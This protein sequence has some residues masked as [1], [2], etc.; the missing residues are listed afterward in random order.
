MHEPKTRLFDGDVRIETIH[1]LGMYRDNEKYLE[2][3]F[4]MLETF[5]LKYDV[6]FKY[7][8]FENNSKDDTREK[9]QQF[10]KTR[11]NSRLILCNVKKDYENIG[12]G[13]NLNRIA[14]LAKLRNKF[15][16]NCLPFP[17]NEWCLIVDSN[18][19]FKQ[20]ILEQVFNT[21]S[22][23][24]DNIAMMCMYTQQLMIPAIHK[25]NT[26]KPILIKHF[27]DTY[28]FYDVNKR[29]FYPKCAFQKCEACSIN[30]A[31]NKNIR[32]PSDQPVVD[33][34]S[35]F[36]GFVF[37]KSDIMNNTKIRW[38][39]VCYDMKT[40][41]SLCEHVIFCDR[42]KTLTDQ[43]IVVLQHIDTL[44]RTI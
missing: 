5:E 14:S 29:T 9:L 21:C 32:V 31:S 22:P 40:N 10:V 23:S 37:I 15:V 36:G 25:T 30:D 44:Y 13:R 4:K 18:I 3:L 12:D 8:F 33:V 34:T 17:S 16:D 39:T 43:R 41:Q 26:D 27:Y 19:Y 28:S 38:D 35:A 24:N 11:K 1:V 6:A 2:F 7:Y 42:L 20:D